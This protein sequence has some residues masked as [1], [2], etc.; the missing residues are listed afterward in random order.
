MSS[1]FD[2][3]VLLHPDGPSEEEEEVCIMLQDCLDL[4]KKCVFR[5]RVAP[6]DSSDH[7]Q[8]EQQEENGNVSSP[9]PNQ[10]PFRYKPEPPSKVWIPFLLLLQLIKY[11]SKAS[12]FS[13]SD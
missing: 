10:Y 3:V 9:K 6:W 13:E 4:R 12:M 1:F 5:E 2:V 11:V 7:R 8:Q